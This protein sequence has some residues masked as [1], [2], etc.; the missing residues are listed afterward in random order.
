MRGICGRPGVFRSI[1]VRPTSIHLTTTRAT[2]VYTCV[3]IFICYIRGKKNVIQ[4]LSARH[5][6]LADKTSDVEALLPSHV[7]SGPKGN[8]RTLLLGFFGKINS[9][10]H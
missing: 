7:I 9:P 10:K 6:T 2:H 8:H 3:A 1:L 4:N 5:T